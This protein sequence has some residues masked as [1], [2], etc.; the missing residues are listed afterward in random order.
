MTLSVLQ[1]RSGPVEGKRWALAKVG[2]LS[3]FWVFPRPC[4]G[5]LSG[6]EPV[7]SYVFWSFSGFVGF[8]TLVLLGFPPFV[9]FL[10]FFP[11]QMRKKIWGFRRRD[12]FE[13]KV[14]GLAWGEHHANSFHEAH[15]RETVS[16]Q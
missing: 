5:F 7:F 13:G 16:G 15:Q 11:A 12:C 10:L 4:V 9:S 1:L 6:V 14:G 3:F 2:G 8:P